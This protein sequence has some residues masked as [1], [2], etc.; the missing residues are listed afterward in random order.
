M[1][2]SL[3]H[4]TTYLLMA[5]LFVPQVSFANRL[6]SSGFELQSM[7]TGMEFDGQLGTGITADTTTKRSGAASLRTLRSG[8]AGSSFVYKHFFGTSDGQYDD[9]YVRVY[10]YIATASNI[11][12]DIIGLKDWDNYWNHV[13]I[14]LNPDR[15]LQA[16][17]IN[18]SDLVVD[19]GSPTGALNLNTWYMIEIKLDET[20]TDVDAEFRID[21]NTFAS[22]DNIQLVERTA[23]AGAGR[24]YLG[25]N[26]SGDFDPA[27]DATADLYFDD[28]AI[29]QGTGSYQ[30]TFAGEGHIVHMQPDSAGDTDNSLSSPNGWQNIDEV[31]PDD[32]TTLAVLD[33]AN[34]VLSVNMES[35]SSAGIGSTNSITL[36]QVG[37]REAAVSAASENWQLGI[38]SQSSGTIFSGTRTTHNDVTYKTNGDV[39]P[40][41]YTL[42]SYVNPQAGGVWTPTL[43]DSAQILASTTDA[44]PDVNIS[45]LWAVVEYTDPTPT[46]EA[47][48]YSYLNSATLILNNGTMWVR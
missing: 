33:A 38:K 41:N 26:T 44:T 14:D 45:A 47:F 27:T 13:Y 15:T 9:F 24:L 25:I 21:G 29:N 18:E 30:T 17:Y 11:R 46:P 22:A 5:A 6:W 1:K 12:T 36:V 3:A 19:I 34:D 4:I 43:L 16:A 10:L 32:A 2:K 20:T 42:T 39:A 37:I 35:A 28:I 23:G 8:S 31:T 7:T 40:L 48:T